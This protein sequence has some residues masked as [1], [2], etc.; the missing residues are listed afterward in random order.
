[1]KFLKKPLI[2]NDDLL[3]IHED[4]LF[5]DTVN[6]QH[7]KLALKQQYNNYSENHGNPFL[8]NAQPLHLDTA[9]AL[10]KKYASSASDFNYIHDI[11][12][13]LSGKCCPLCGYQGTVQVDHFLPVTEYPEFYIYSDNLVPACKCNQTKSKKIKGTHPNERFL[14]PY[15]DVALK[16]RLLR[17]KFDKLNIESEELTI[18]LELNIPSTHASYQTAKYHLDNIIIH[19]E[20]CEYLEKEFESLIKNPNLAL[21]RHWKKNGNSSEI[22]LRQTIKTVLEIHDDTTESLNNWNS[23]L[24]FSILNDPLALSYVYSKVK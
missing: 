12:H 10:Q 16:E 13:H 6:R 15:F 14:H 22:D 24:F 5:P 3:D 21:L 11:R 8:I 7:V 1:M 20:I 17:I 9:A 4:D 19:T 23:I 18:H 2:N